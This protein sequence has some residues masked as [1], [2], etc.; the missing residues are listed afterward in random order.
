MVTDFGLAKLDQYYELPLDSLSANGI[1]ELT[2][3]RP[4]PRWVGVKNVTPEINEHFQ[5][6]AAAI[7]EEKNTRRVHLDAIFWGGRSTAKKKK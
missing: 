3:V 6:L 5:E 4:R 7:A 1:R 2:S